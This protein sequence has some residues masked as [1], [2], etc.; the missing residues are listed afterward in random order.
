M[1][2]KYRVV[3]LKRGSLTVDRSSLIYGVDYGI[4]ME[5]PIWMAGIE[6]NGQKILV[7]TGIRSSEWVGENIAPCRQE[8]DETLEGAIKSIGWNVDTINI[9]IN[10]HLHY[11]H[12]G[13]NCLF[14][15]ARFFVSETEWEHARFPIETQKI[16]YDG[17]WSCGSVNYFSYIFVSDHYEVLP[18]IR[19]ISTPGHT[20]GHISVLVNTKEGVLAITGDAANLPENLVKMTPPGIVYDVQTALYSLKQLASYSDMLLTGHDPEIRKFQDS[21]FKRFR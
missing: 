19:L 10:T 17:S 16:F 21:N 15:N 8:T 5:V 6:G 7:D 3:A 14:A 4:N 12:C 18:G 13:G 9:I 1:I 20:P 2:P 11:D